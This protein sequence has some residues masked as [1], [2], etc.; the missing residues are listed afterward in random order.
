MKKKPKKEIHTMLI[1][2]NE[3]RPAGLRKPAGPLNNIQL[4]G[5]GVDTDHLDVMQG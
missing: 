3:V 1:G 2:V 4:S 5:M